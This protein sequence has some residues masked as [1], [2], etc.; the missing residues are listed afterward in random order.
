MTK[1]EIRRAPA[2]S[3][4]LRALLLIS[5]I[6]PTLAGSGC[7]RAGGQGEMVV[8]IEKRIETFDPRA[9]SDSAV[10]RMR[11]LM[12]NGLTRKDDKFNPVPDLAERF[13]SSP[14]YKAFAFYLR[15]NVRFHNGRTLSAADVKYTFDTMLAEGF[16]SDKRADLKR[17]GVSVELDTSNPLKATFRCENPC[18]G[19]ANT[20][21]P[22][23]IIPEGTSDEQARRPM[24]T[25]P[26]KFESYTEDQEV[27]LTSFDDY[28]EGSPSIKRLS[29]RIIPDNSTR[30]SELRKG[31]VDLA[32]NADFDPVTVESL[33]SAPGITVKITEGT[34]ITHLGVNLQDPILKDRRVR[35]ALAYA[36]DREAI[37]RDVL[38]GQASPARSVLPQSQWAYEP[39]VADYKYDPDRAKRLLAEAG[40]SN[41]KLSL[42]TSPVSVSRKIGEAIQEQMRRIGVEIELQ[43]LERQ[44]L[45]QDMIEGNFQLYLNTLVGGNQNPDIFRLVYGSGSIPPN[46]QNRSRYS[47]PQLDK[48]LNEAQTAP[49]ERRKEIFSQVQKT[50]AEDLPQIYLWYPSTVIVYRNRI[51]NVTVDPSG[52]W[53]AIRNMKAGS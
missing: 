1:V 42:K 46:G 27:V 36:I 4:L 2:P 29:V 37:I 39:N 5:F 35:Q 47:N 19:L 28:F 41:L 24:G 18:P 30:E 45:T 25:G 23:G 17:D 7:G 48:L 8:M 10:E 32:I 34:N 44:K 38:R 53:S 31:S 3:S 40:K 52:D 15:P 43:S 20:V 13:E 12:F 14:D 51:S 6:A 21:L 16:A 33:Q 11:Q 49:L 22:I 26:F 9:K 50:L